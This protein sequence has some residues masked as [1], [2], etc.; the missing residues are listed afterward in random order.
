MDG[1]IGSPI[2]VHT[3]FNPILHC[4]LAEASQTWN[5]LQ[6]SRSQASAAKTTF[7][8]EVLP[9]SS[10][11]QSGNP[12]SRPHLPYNPKSLVHDNAQYQVYSN[13]FQNDHFGADRRGEFWVSCRSAWCT[14]FD[15]NN[16]ASHLLSVLTHQWVDTILLQLCN[17]LSNP[18]TKCFLS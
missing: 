6:L 1:Q 14:Y 3:R 11:D 12:S 8:I 13:N 4:G 2:N 10:N 16:N 5:V 17:A 15:P 18:K 9:L 7:S